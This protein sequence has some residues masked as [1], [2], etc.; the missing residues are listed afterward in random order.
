MS[1]IGTVANGVVVLPEG[2]SFPE[3]TEVE[4][5]AL[6]DFE[7]ALTAEEEDLKAVKD[8][9][10]EWRAGDEG[11]PLKDAFDEICGGK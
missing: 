2:I 7:Q 9:I 5:T 8:A 4:V 10:K 11:L 6:A 1:V 3:G